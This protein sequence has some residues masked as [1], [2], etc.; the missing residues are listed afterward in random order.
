MLINLF[1]N[2]FTIKLKKKKKVENYLT[3][4]LGIPKVYR[5]FQVKIIFLAILSRFSNSSQ[6]PRM[7][8]KLGSEF[9]DP[10]IQIFNMF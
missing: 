6:S 1:K 7:I 4:K 8:E 5:S 3:K 10:K 9:W 2:K